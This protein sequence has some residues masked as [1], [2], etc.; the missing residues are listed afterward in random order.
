MGKEKLTIFTYIVQAYGLC[1]QLEPRLTV[2]G[3]TMNIKL[4]IS[5]CLQVAVIFPTSA[6]HVGVGSIVQNSM[7][8]DEKPAACPAATQKKAHILNEAAGYVLM[9]KRRILQINHRD[10]PPHSPP[11]SYTTL[12]LLTHGFHEEEKPLHIFFSVVYSSVGRK[13]KKREE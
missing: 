12:F 9:H 4:M 10:D 3:G 7:H 8:H 11:R 1:P 13:R 2:L 6:G 5:N